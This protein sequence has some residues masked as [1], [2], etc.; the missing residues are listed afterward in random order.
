VFLGTY[1]YS[2]AARKLEKMR[3]AGWF[4]SNRTFSLGVEIV[5]YNDH[6]KSGG[7]YAFTHERNPET[8]R[9][10]TGVGIFK[11]IYPTSYDE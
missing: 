11:T 1:N 2:Q 10:E 9:F 3:K 8:G 7:I 4:D 6:M 5:T